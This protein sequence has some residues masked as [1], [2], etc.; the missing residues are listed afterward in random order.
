MP[1]LARFHPFLV[2]AALVAGCWH[3]WDK[4]N[5][6]LVESENLAPT[7][8]GCVV[9]GTVLNKGHHTLRVFIVWEAHDR[10]DDEIGPAEVEIPDLPG[11]VRRDYESTRFRDH[12]G[13]RP[14]C[15]EIRR[16]ER[17]KSAFHD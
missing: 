9:R 13:D 7:S 16:I 10:D 12:D 3:D 6:V 4:E 1:R 5:D 11:G 14:R 2:L 17:D 15:T 8:G